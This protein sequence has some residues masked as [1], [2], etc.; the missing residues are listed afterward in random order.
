MNRAEVWEAETR[1]RDASSSEKNNKT[2]SNQLV[3]GNKGDPMCD[4]PTLYVCW[5]FCRYIIF[6][7]VWLAHVNGILTT[8]FFS[9]LKPFRCNVN[10]LLSCPQKIECTIK[11]P[12]A[13]DV[14][15]STAQKKERK[16]LLIF[17]NPSATNSVIDETA[18]S[19][20]FFQRTMF[21]NL[22]ISKWSDFR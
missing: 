11:Q 19:N 17:S 21:G 14:L 4:I 9:T 6:A 2:E 3:I 8:V 1:S 22:R 7:V 18:Q 15:I 20:N 5:F 10:P 12:V 16:A 13:R